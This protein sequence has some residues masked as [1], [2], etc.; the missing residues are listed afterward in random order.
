LDITSE[1]SLGGYLKDHLMSVRIDSLQ[2]MALSMVG[3][4]VFA[5]MFVGAAVPVLPIA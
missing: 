5:A 3:A 1:W 2:R 4:L